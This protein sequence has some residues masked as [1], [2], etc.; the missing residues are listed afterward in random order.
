MEDIQQKRL[1]N[2]QC[3]FEKLQ[4]LEKSNK[5]RL[6][7]CPQNSSNNAHMFYIICKN[8]EERTALIAHLKSKQINA[9]FHYISLHKSPYYTDKHD[10]RVLPMVD[11]YSDTLLRLPMYYELEKADIDR[12]TEEIYKFYNEK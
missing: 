12:I 6:P 3:Y 5:I 10:G 8:L 1:A 11:F 4:P 9:V 7:F 2:W